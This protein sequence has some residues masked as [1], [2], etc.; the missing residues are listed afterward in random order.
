MLLMKHVPAIHLLY[1]SGMACENYHFEQ[2]GYVAN[3]TILDQQGH[4]V[5]SLANNEVLGVEGFIRWDGDRDDGSRARAGYYMVWFE[6][7]NVDG[8]I[9][10][11]RKR[12]VVMYR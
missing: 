11:F 12:V 1:L 5:K 8:K 6:V 10:T 4:T 2:S 7:F 9:S 3:A